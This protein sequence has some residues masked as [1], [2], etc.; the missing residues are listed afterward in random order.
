[1]K[2]NFA[3]MSQLTYG[4]ALPAEDYSDDAY[5]LSFLG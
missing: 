4:L 3:N 2:M 5:A 1:M